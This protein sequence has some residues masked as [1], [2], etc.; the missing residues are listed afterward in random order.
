[1]FAH[2]Y[3]LLYGKTSDGRVV[4]DWGADYTYTTIFLFFS[5]SKLNKTNDAG[6]FGLIM[7]TFF[8]GVVLYHS[9]L[10]MEK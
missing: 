8:R 7:A 1:M 6:H 2:N 9:G 3:S 4:E 5:K 10:K